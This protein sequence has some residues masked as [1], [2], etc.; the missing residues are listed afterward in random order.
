MKINLCIFFF[1]WGGWLLAQS[2]Q[3]SEEVLA[4]EALE[5][6]E[7]DDFVQSISLYSKLYS[8]YNDNA[9]YC[10]R[11][12]A[13]KL[14]GEEDKEEPLTFLERAQ[15]MGCTDPDLYFYLAKAYH[16]NYRFKDAITYYKKYQSTGKKRKKLPVSQEIKMC[17]NGQTLLQKITDISVRDKKQIKRTDFHRS[18][19]SIGLKGKVIKV[20]PLFLSKKDKQL[21]YKPLMYSDPSYQKLFFTSYGDK[22][23]NST[24]IY[25]VSK[26]KNS[27]FSDPVK[28][29]SHINTE[30]DED[31][32]FLH[33]DGVTL[34]FASKGH[35]SMGGYDIFKTTYNSNDNSWSTPENLDF[36]I[37]SPGDD[38]MYVTNEDFSKAIFASTRNAN[39]GNCH[40]YTI[41]VGKVAI[42]QTVVEGTYSSQIDKSPKIIVKRSGT[43]DVIASVSVDSST[44]KY[45]YAIP[46]GGAFDVFIES[47][48]AE[49][50]HKG[51]ITVPYQT[52][53]V[54]LNQELN[55]DAIAGEE[56]LD[57]INKFNEKSSISDLAIKAQLLKQKEALEVNYQ[58]IQP[59]DNQSQIDNTAI[60]ET[61][62][63]EKSNE[64]QTLALSMADKEQ[65]KIEKI[66]S[67]IAAI[68]S[69]SATE[70]ND[71]FTQ[72]VLNEL[73]KKKA[74]HQDIKQQFEQIASQINQAASQ[75][76][77][78]A[79][80]NKISALDTEPEGAHLT[81]YTDELSEIQE[82]SGPVYKKLELLEI[83]R[84]NL[85][86]DLSTLED[87]LKTA[88]KKEQHDIHDQIHLLKDDIEQINTQ[89]P[90]L[91]TELNTYREASAK[92]KE[93]Q[94]KAK[95]FLDQLTLDDTQNQIAENNI[96]PPKEEQIE[97]EEQTNN[98][99]TQ[100]SKNQNNVELPTND[101]SEKEDQ[102][103]LTTENLTENSITQ[104]AKNKEE[105]ALK[106]QALLDGYAQQIDSLNTLDNTPENNALKKTTLEQWNSQI[107]AK[108]AALESESADESSTS[109]EQN[110]IELNNLKGQLTLNQTFLNELTSASKLPKEEASDII[111][112]NSNTTSAEND[113]NESLSLSNPSKT[114]QY[115][116]TT[117][118][119]LIDQHTESSKKLDTSKQVE[120]ELSTQRANEKNKKKRKEIE[121]E[122]VKAIQE[123]SAIQGELDALASAKEAAK[124][125][126]EANVKDYD[127]L[128]Q[129]DALLKQLDALN[130]TIS[131]DSLQTAQ[132]SQ[133]ISEM[134][135]KKRKAMQY[136]LDS[137]EAAQHY[138]LSKQK[139]LSTLY[140]EIKTLEEKQTAVFV[141][142][143]M[144]ENTLKLRLTQDEFNT[145][146][147]DS[148]FDQYAQNLKTIEE[149]KKKI[150]SIKSANVSYSE[151]PEKVKEID[152]LSATSLELLTQ[153]ASILQDKE[154]KTAKDFLA[155]TTSFKQYT[156]DTQTN[157]T[158]LV[159]ADSSALEEPSEIDLEDKTNPIVEGLTIVKSISKRTIEMNPTLPKGVSYKVQ[160][161]A[162]RN[163]IPEDLFAEF[164]PLT[165]EQT[166]SGLTRYMAGFFTEFETANQ[167]KNKIRAL[168]YSDAFV[169]AYNN[170]NRT[171]VS[172]AKKLSPDA[173][174]ISTPAP[175]QNIDN[176]SSLV[177]SDEPTQKTDHKADEKMAQ[178]IKDIEKLNQPYFTIQVGAYRGV[179]KNNRLQAISPLKADLKSGG[180]VK[181][182]TGV[183]LNVDEAI[184]RRNAIAE[185]YN[186]PDAF[187]V[188]YHQG[189]KITIAD[190]K[191]MIDP[192]MAA[193][194]AKDLEEAEQ[195]VKNDFTAPNQ[196]EN[197]S[198][199]NE[200]NL[201]SKANETAPVNG[202]TIVIYTQND[203]VPLEDFDLITSIDS[204]YN[205]FSLKHENGFNVYS[206]GN[207]KDAQSANDLLNILKETYAIDPKVQEVKDGI[208]LAE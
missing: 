52:E 63:E 203:F 205:V 85:K 71:P 123:T 172:E 139:T 197:T 175:T 112:E 98:S 51:T 80:V 121:K 88:K 2:D 110:Q 5:S 9:N 160:V 16:L 142:D 168:G 192:S 23:E 190:A 167:A 83:E 170:S 131:D 103:E 161:G 173:S 22:S 19:H 4:K 127:N 181:Y 195:D 125:I 96:I 18:F 10:F 31:F 34:F 53:L 33:P 38:F 196:P 44:G 143:L 183:F 20:P 47:D 37:N 135:K 7:S 42:T 202:Y 105:I 108:I 72:E 82:K 124:K 91:Q 136:K 156:K 133:D 101:Q 177:S 137:T 118:T 116:E 3:L 113:I 43:D 102:S 146:S 77:I 204:T 70:K 164:N 141:E 122:L 159:S 66:N 87:K 28:L 115:I 114:N 90:P 158:A 180:W 99:E 106:E 153:N 25:Y 155:Y 169:V 56:S 107:D 62:Q 35:N 174:Q 15:N 165:G 46:N 199:S 48:K 189:E 145:L 186:I 11:Y 79:T 201:S 152:D 69:L 163:P 182:T 68:S 57:I 60:K 171:S 40:V 126:K 49:S 117:N 76:D 120:S 36:A 119:T 104:N 140:N 27:E 64:H 78:N 61:D 132:L 100:T 74:H 193:L 84:T 24:D 187:V 13:S 1:L 150:K 208:V 12:G 81:L 151:D 134:K 178:T 207:F 149:N 26:L 89:I 50:I 94:N 30:F 191:E 67:R 29:P 179:P 21:S 39:F 188:A 147:E 206:T 92:V 162:F 97:L 144:Q 200:T 128:F 111:S 14:M 8:N 59:I 32:V 58:D 176:N 130:N 198:T 157:T 65:E 93:K 154:A 109:S 86:D 54:S 75:E 55:L 148:D 17:E 138:N 166:P 129:S 184:A 194:L 95:S 185:Q 45:A 73:Q 6:F 41:D